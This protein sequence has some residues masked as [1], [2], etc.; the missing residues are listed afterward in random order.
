MA[1]VAGTASPEA[2]ALTPD[3]RRKKWT[4]PETGIVIAATMRKTAAELV[5][6]T[7]EPNI[8]A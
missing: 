8:V 7:Q 1:A 6:V 4:E 3:V 5:V 2:A